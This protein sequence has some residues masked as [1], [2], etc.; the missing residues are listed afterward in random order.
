MKKSSQCGIVSLIIS[1]LKLQYIKNAQYIL[2]DRNV[3]KITCKLQ[4]VNKYNSALGGLGILWY[5]SNAQNYTRAKQVH[6]VSNQD[7]Q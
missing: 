1:I 7:M 2:V 5:I 6:S 3:Y 4:V